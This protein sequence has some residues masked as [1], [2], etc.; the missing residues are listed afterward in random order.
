MLVIRQ[1]VGLRHFCIAFTFQTLKLRLSFINSSKLVL[2]FT[3][4][5][6][7]LLSTLWARIFFSLRR[8]RSIPVFLSPVLCTTFKKWSLHRSRFIVFINIVCKCYDSY[9]VLWSLSIKSSETNFVLK[10]NIVYSKKMFT[11]GFARIQGYAF[12][13]RGRLACVLQLVCCTLNLLP[14]IW[15]EGWKDYWRDQK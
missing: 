14:P 10:V 3:L 6:T 13:L 5:R 8:H 1:T 12:V 15:C 7:L 11:C 2:S 9:G 4:S